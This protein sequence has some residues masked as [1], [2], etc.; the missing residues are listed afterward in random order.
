M[1]SPVD[2]SASSRSESSDASS[3]APSGHGGKSGDAYEAG[4]L[5]ALTELNGMKGSSLEEIG[6]HMQARLPGGKEL[7]YET[8]VRALNRLATAGDVVRVMETEDVFKLSVMYKRLNALDYFLPWDCESSDDEDPSY[9][10]GITVAVNT[11]KFF[12]EETSTAEEIG[13]QV[14]VE[15]SYPGLWDDDAFM[16]ALDELVKEGKILRSEAVTGELRYG[17]SVEKK[18]ASGM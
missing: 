6:S 7:S 2:P 13:E 4:I 14:Q 10:E 3:S 11:L 5:R 16:A 17:L 9:R 8:L 18:K 1:S 12:G 15:E